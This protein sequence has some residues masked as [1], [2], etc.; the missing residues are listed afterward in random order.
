M[1]SEKS[2]ADWSERRSGQ[3]HPFVA[4]VWFCR[5]GPEDDDSKQLIDGLAKTAD[6]SSTGLGF[7]SNEPIPPGERIFLEVS[8][9]KVSVSCVAR[10]VHCGFR[11]GGRFRIGV[12]FLIVPP[13][14]RLVL[15]TQF[16]TK[17]AEQ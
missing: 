14:D 5:L 10:V 12:R 1:S 2:P 3:R 7:D 6:V 16:G 4:L 9:R 17:R 11:R 15:R 8:V 13:N